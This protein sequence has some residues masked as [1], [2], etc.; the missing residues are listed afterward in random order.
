MQKEIISD[1]K[2][3]AYKQ[4]ETYISTINHDLKI[5]TLA[6]IR[7]LEL[8]ADGSLGGLNPQ[9]SEIVNLTLDSCRSMYEMMSNILY[10][11]KYENLEIIPNI[12]KFDVVKLLN[13]C[14][15]MFQTLCK[16]DINAKIKSAKSQ[17]CIFA[18]KE[19]F[20]K[21]VQNLLGYCFSSADDNVF[22]D[23]NFNSSNLFLT[24]S[25]EN[26][27]MKNTGFRNMF[28]R[29][30]TSDEKLDKIG[31]NIRLYLAKQIITANKGELYLKTNRTKFTCTVKM[32]LGF[33]DE[34][35]KL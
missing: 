33:S 1:Y 3:E 32:P 28:N 8:L 17:M 7:A 14:F 10:S 19:Q 2:I 12:E 26:L 5:P 21:A 13:D 24:F 30:T 15:D 11:Y 34:I 31:T 35:F 6:Q 25:F 16:K 9:Q 22:C 23:L 29:F 18:D 4:R 20:K 27:Y